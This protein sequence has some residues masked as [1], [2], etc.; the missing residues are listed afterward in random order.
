MKRTRTTNNDAQKKRD[1]DRCEY[2]LKLNNK[3]LL[4][5]KEYIVINHDTWCSKSWDIDTYYEYI[6]TNL[7]DM[8]Q[9]RLTNG[10]GY[11]EKDLLQMLYDITDA[12]AYLQRSRFDH[13][14]IRPEYIAVD[15]A[16]HYILCDHLLEGGN[17]D[18]N[19]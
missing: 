15:Q 13:G 18:V 6:P 11:E 19:V 5:F 14:V 8:N 7:V 2:R 9:H 17:F 1:I 12:C 3:K 10:N 16:G 4:Q